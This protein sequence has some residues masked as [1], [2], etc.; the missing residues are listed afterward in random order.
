MPRR[1]RFISVGDNVAWRDNHGEAEPA[2]ATVLRIEVVDDPEDKY[3]REVKEIH[4]AHKD[5]CVFTLQ[6]EGQRFK[7]WARG[8]QI[9]S[10][11]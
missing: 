3:G 2:T 5:R 4:F 11:H 6:P 9:I 7:K 8:E 10:L 1:K